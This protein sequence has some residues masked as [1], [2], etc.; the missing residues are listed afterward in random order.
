[1]TLLKTQYCTQKL[2]QYC[3]ELRNLQHFLW[4][5]LLKNYF[6]TSKRAKE[7]NN[8]EN[9][10]VMKLKKKNSYEFFLFC[11]CIV[12]ESRIEFELKI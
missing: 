9:E 10:F 8:N 2:T 12:N 11:L 1:M 3:V 5:N 7:Q 4:Q 6:Q